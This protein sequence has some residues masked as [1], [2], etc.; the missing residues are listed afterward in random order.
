MQ[1][2]A[3]NDGIT[4]TIASSF[5]DFERQLM[6][7][8]NKYQGI[9]PVYDKQGDK[10]DIEE[11]DEWQRVQAILLYSAMPGTSR[12]HWGT[13]IDVYDTATI[14]ADY[15][16]QLE[17]DEYELNGPF[18]HLSQWL[19][20]NCAKFNFYRPYLKDK[21][22]VAPELWH[23]SHFAVAQAY[24]LDF[25]TNAD[26][27]LTLLADKKICGLAAIEQH[28]DYILQQYVYNVEQA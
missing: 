4:L 10:V 26:K 9:R 11:L 28:F 21:G 17:P 18:Y 13:D 8:N 15:Q 16:L 22:G 14:D 23:L 19:S 3:K 1:A 24:Q 20:E 2:Q 25:K 6:I 5:R 7:W 27:L 12:H